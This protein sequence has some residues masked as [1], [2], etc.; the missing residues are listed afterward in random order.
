MIDI[1]VLRLN[2]NWLD[3]SEKIIEENK[4]DTGS[5]LMHYKATYLK[6]VNETDVLIKYATP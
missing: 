5:H 3:N 1:V 2:G 6:D 4:P